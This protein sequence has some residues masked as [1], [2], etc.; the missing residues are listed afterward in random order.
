MSKKKS[1]AII[2]TSAPFAQPHAKDALDISLIMGSYEQDTHLFFI[3]DGVWQLVDK[4]QPEI[5]SIKNFL[6]TFSA[7][8]F[9][10]LNNVYICESSLEDRGLDISFHIENVKV[11][12]PSE[13]SKRLHLL[14]TILTF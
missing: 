7:F 10:D 1:I 3:G 14:D 4:Q 8:E 6:K 13:L 12:S 11:L 2:N 5:I 9:Y